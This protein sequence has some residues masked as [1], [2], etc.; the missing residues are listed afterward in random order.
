[1][2]TNMTIFKY[3]EYSCLCICNAGNAKVIG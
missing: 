1:M 3:L 2:P